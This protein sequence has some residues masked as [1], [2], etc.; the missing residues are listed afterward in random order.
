MYEIKNLNKTFESNGKDINAVLNVSLKILEGEIFGIIGSSGAGKSTLI[1][2]LNLLEKPDSGQVIFKGEDLMTLSKKQIRTKRKKIGMVFQNFNL[3]ESRTVFENVAFPINNKSKDQINEKVLQLLEIVGI[4]DKA[5]AYPNQLSGGQK[6]RV[7]IARAL[8]NEP[9]VLL[10]DEATSALDPQTTKSILNLLKELNTTLNLTI[11]IITHEMDV[12]KAICDKVAI[13]SEGIVVEV[14]KVI[15]I[16]TDAKNPIS[17]KLINE[18]FN[19]GEIKE[20]VARNN[21][22]K[23]NSH[24]YELV[25]KQDSSSKALISRLIKEFDLDVNIIAGTIEIIS[26][27]SI[28]HLIVAIDGDS[29]KVTAGLKFLFDNAV[30]IKEVDVSA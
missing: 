22:L 9:D 19:I 17:K 8:A 29:D 10:C 12:I 25:Y 16:F 20:L 26:N 21:I 14:D 13:M 24:L 2:C 11:I 5:N 4:S 3:L 6:Q 23:A 27:E 1:R 30:I 7:A 15:N 18:N 28:G